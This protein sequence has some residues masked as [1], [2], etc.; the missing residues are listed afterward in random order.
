MRLFAAVHFSMEAKASLLDA[1]DDLRRQ[2]DGNFT[3]EEN[4]HLTLAFIGETNNLKGA[5][6]AL[7]RVEGAPFK[8]RLRGAGHFGDLWWAGLEKCPPLEKLAANTQRALRKAGFPIEERPFRAHVTLARQVRP[9]GDGIFL[10]VHPAETRVTR[11]SLMK[12]ERIDGRLTYT[13]VWSKA[14]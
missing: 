11:L 9:L 14:L 3:R 6:A 1:M 5:I 10:R 12:S 13:E 8:L 7:E 4:L 2:A